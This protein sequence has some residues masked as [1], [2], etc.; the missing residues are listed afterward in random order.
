MVRSFPRE[1]VAFLPLSMFEAWMN[2]N[3]F[4][5][6]VKEITADGGGNWEASPITAGGQNNT[7]TTLTVQS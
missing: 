1:L 5:C 3:V 6:W 4:G 2:P 7:I